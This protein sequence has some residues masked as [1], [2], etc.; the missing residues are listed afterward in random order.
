M[1]E[2]IGMLCGLNYLALCGRNSEALH[3][4]EQT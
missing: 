4:E 2:Q 3:W 1:G